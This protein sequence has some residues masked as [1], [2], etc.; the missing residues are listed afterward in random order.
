MAKSTFSWRRDTWV[1]P[2]LARYK[3][4]LLLALTLGVCTIVFAMGL[5]FVAG[6]LIGQSAERPYSVLMLGAPLL[7]VRVFGVGKP[8]I[9]YFERLASHDW[10]LRM[11]SSL[12][13]RLYQSFDKQ[14]IF[15]RSTYRLGDALG[16]LAEDIGHIQNL[17]LRTIF[18][19]VI[20]W[21]IG[22][23]LVIAFGV[24]TWWMAGVAALLM[25]LEL[26]VVPAAS[27]AVNGARQTKLKR[28]K[29]DLYT[30]MTDNVLGITDWV[31]SG[32]KRDYLD[33]YKHTQHTLRALEADAHRFDRKRDFLMQVAFTL[34]AVAIFLWAAWYF[35]TPG[36]AGGNANYV[37]AFVLGYFPLIDAIAPL[38]VAAVE[39][40]GHKDSIERLNNLPN[41]DEPSA[42]DAPCAS[43]S[44]NN[45]AKENTPAVQNVQNLA[46]VPNSVGS[47]TRPQE[48]FDLVLKEVSFAYEKDFKQNSATITAKNSSTPASRS[49]LDN[50]SLTI[51]QGQQVALHG[52]SGVG[53]STLAALIRGDLMP[54]SGTITLGGIATC[55][56]GNDAS[57]YF[58]VIQQ[59]TYL[60]NTTL[61]ENLL[62]ANGEADDE[63]LLDLLERVG[64][65]TLMKRLPEGLDTMVDE[66]GLRFSG[67]ERHR[68]ALARVLLQDAPVIILDE[69]SVGL[70]PA[71]ESQV[72]DTVFEVLKNKT[73]IMI[74]HHLQGIQH[75][76]RVLFLDK[77]TITLDG[78]P[79]YLQKTNVH[80]QALLA[81]ETSSLLTSK[82]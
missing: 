75:M 52:K 35:A 55:A 26:F 6:L 31:L 60:F 29:S 33:Q 76:D 1:A 79:A 38:S 74:T 14:G 13:K 3:K 5:M 4:T 69:P 44:V 19:T 61:R 36:V 37:L 32:R 30:T 49:I 63:E 51:P 28:I 47:P 58:G 23:G 50:V 18:P 45:T 67:G 27:V 59:N 65:N 78:S 22:L 73:I 10:V 48:P 80:F 40:Q 68:I 12:R 9:Q 8:V 46:G 11:T 21:T 82:L 71:T 15:F 24:F 66:A 54:G 57:R 34:G 72:L 81:L 20:G 16:L 43:A 17:Y 39:G 56:L 70:D 41:P 77:G 64:L 2:Y 53:K 62:I 42:S 7:L 25:L